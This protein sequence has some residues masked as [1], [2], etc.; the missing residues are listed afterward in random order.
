MLRFPFCVAK[1]SIIFFLCKSREQFLE[2]FLF[3][4]FVTVGFRRFFKKLQ[5]ICG[6]EAD[7]G[8]VL[9]LLVVK[10]LED[11]RLFLTL[12]KTPRFKGIESNLFLT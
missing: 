3:E 11:W 10:L 8:G 1:V 7:F 5:A 9:G 4:W 12:P 6:E 2:I